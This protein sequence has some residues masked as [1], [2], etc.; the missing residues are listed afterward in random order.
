ML[1]LQL[2]CHANLHKTYFVLWLF[3][4]LKSIFIIIM[5]CLYITW[6]CISNNQDLAHFQSLNP[7]CSTEMHSMPYGMAVVISQ[8]SYTPFKIS[9]Y[10][11]FSSM[12]VLITI[13]HSSAVITLA[14]VI[15]A[16][17]YSMQ[18]VVVYA[19]SR[20]H[21]QHFVTVCVLMQYYYYCTKAR[22]SVHC[23]LFCGR[24][25]SVHV[26]AFVSFQTCGYDGPLG[27]LHNCIF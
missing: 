3:L 15:L 2:I 20:W 17:D 6:F 4:K 26:H 1:N 12:S 11:C 18:T 16:S 21:I 5:V 10:L 19:H 24:R 25:L 7:S 23:L 14:P 27:Y 22:A 13:C 8:L 9:H